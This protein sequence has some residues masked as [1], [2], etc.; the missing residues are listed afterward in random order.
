MEDCPHLCAQATGASEE[1]AYAA[2][3]VEESVDS[4]TPAKNATT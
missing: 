2:M 4:A 3:I 1:A